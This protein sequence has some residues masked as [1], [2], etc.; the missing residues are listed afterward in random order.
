MQKPSS[1]PSTRPKPQLVRT[2]PHHRLSRVSLV[3]GP[4][5]N[6]LFQGSLPQTRTSRLT[7]IPVAC[8]ANSW[9]FLGISLFVPF[10]RLHSIVN[11]SHFPALR[12]ATRAG[13][14]HSTDFKLLNWASFFSQWE[15]NNPLKSK[16]YRFAKHS[17]HRLIW[18][19]NPNKFS[20]FSSPAAGDA[21]LLRTGNNK[22]FLNPPGKEPRKPVIGTDSSRALLVKCTVIVSKPKPHYY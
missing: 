9:D 10:G 22:I 7:H 6:S 16:Q 15:I 2:T 13:F 20:A 21:V 5:S 19:E 14:F 11:I 8:W 1:S 4:V 12:S 3:S 17:R 18:S